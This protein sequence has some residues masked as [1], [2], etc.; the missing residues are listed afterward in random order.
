MIKRIC[1]TCGESFVAKLSEVNRGGGVT[2]PPR[3]VSILQAV[4]RAGT[5]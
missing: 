2:L 3:V 4:N 1:L 5:Y